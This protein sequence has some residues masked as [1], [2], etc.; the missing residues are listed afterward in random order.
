MARPTVTEQVNA[1]QSR[2]VGS[3]GLE[4]QRRFLQEQG[5][6]EEVVKTMLSSRKPSTRS[7]YNAKWQKFCDWCG[8]RGINPT[9]VSVPIICDFLQYLYNQGFQ[10]STITGYVS[11]ISIAHPEFF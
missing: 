5:F 10:Y 6:S 4:N 7:L 9:L 2:G 11:A 1:R 3:G 8:E